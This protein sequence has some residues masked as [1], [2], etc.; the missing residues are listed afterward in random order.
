MLCALTV[1]LG[2]DLHQLLISSG[3]RI[4]AQN[5]LSLGRVAPQVI[6]IGRAEPL[7]IHADQ[8]LAGSCIIAL[9]VDAG[10]LPADGNAVRCESLL[11]EVADGMLHAGSD[12][13][14]LR[15]ILLHDQPHTLDVILGVAPVAQGVHYHP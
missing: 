4:P 6:D 8:H 3:L 2:H 10:A 9:F 1:V 7:G 15:L 13:E 11:G 5:S 14:V 12:D